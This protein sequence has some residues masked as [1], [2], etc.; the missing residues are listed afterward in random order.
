M[1]LPPLTGCTILF[2]GDPVVVNNFNFMVVSTSLSPLNQLTPGAIMVTPFADARRAQ[3]TFAGTGTTTSTGFKVSGTD[4]AQYE[5]DFNWDP[6]VSGAEDDLQDPVTFPGTATVT[7][8]LC[9]GQFFGGATCPTFA[10][11]TNTLTV[12]SDGKPA[13]AIPV[14]TTPLSPPLVLP[15]G[16]IGTTSLVDLEA[17]GTTLQIEGFSTAVLT[18]PEP[19]VFGLVAG[20][21]LAL[22]LRRRQPM[23]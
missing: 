12:F 1:L 7:T 23:L 9:N 22:A 17:N 5:I 20:G 19:A 15:G 11:P 10:S 8:K 4:F 3:L 14:A 2:N 16:R 13:D 6:Q 18:T 21:I